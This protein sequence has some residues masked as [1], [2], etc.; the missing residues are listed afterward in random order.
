MRTGV[1]NAD[2]PRDRAAQYALEVDLEDSPL[3]GRP[4]ERRLR[5][6]RSDSTTQLLSL[7]GPLA[8][9]RR[10]R[11][12][13]LG[14]EEHE[15]RLREAWVELAATCDGDAEEFERRWRDAAE[16][17]SFF[18]VN[19]LIARHNRNFPA[20][21]RLPMNPRTGDFVEING[22]PYRREP[23]GA[24]W[25]LERFPLDLAAAAGAAE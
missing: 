5:N 23:V 7:G 21:A 8:W 10:L 6:F 25:V 17:W 11:E 3:R 15:R 4:L 18:D 16:A 9:M 20:E 19:D 13:E 22:R 14:L 24:A 12:I 2:T 1:S